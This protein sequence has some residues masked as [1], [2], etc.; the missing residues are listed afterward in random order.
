MWG[1]SIAGVLQD[2]ECPRSGHLILHIRFGL[3]LLLDVMAKN[4]HEI[5]ENENTPWKINV[6]PKNGGLEHDF[7]F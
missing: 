7:P 4:A 5:V 1:T 2:K 6:Q 3:D